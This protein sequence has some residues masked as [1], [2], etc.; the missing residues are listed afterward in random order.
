MP[1]S[2][3]RTARVVI[4]RYGTTFATDA[5]IT[6]RDKPSPLWRLLVLTSLF[7]RTH[8]CGHRRTFCA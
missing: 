5:G 6:L 2:R 8:R 7:G 1:A 4:E 3:E